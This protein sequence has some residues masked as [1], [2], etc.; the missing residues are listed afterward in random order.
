MLV[1]KLSLSFLSYFFLPPSHQSCFSFSFFV[2]PYLSFRLVLINF[3]FLTSRKLEP[4]GKLFSTLFLSSFFSFLLVSNL[5][6]F[7]P[8][9]VFPLVLFC[10]QSATFC[11]SNEMENCPYVLSSFLLVIKTHFQLLI[12]SS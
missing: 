6:F 11:N 9:L 1:E 3:N 4:V 12:L 7:P 10:L 8:S 5:T 2:I